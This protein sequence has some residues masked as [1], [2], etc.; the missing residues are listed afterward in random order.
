MGFAAGS[1][2]PTALSTPPAPATRRLLQR[3]MKTF[4]QGARV[5]PRPAVPAR[6]ATN[7][8]GTG[9]TTDTG[10]RWFRNARHQWQANRDNHCHFPNAIEASK[11]YHDAIVAN[12]FLDP[13]D[14]MEDR[15][16]TR[17]NSSH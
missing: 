6:P 7:Q 9:M 5:W 11:I 12:R 17:L 13:E 14:R 1:T 2:H 16:S 4:S 3:A 8:R 15:K 10:R